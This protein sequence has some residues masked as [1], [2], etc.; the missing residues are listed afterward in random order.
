LAALGEAVRQKTALR[1]IEEHLEKQ[2]GRYV[3]DYDSHIRQGSKAL[4]VGRGP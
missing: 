3:S 1:E 2:S 4:V